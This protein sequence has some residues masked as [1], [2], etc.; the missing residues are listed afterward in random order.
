[1]ENFWKI[2][3][4][5]SVFAFKSPWV[6]VILGVAIIGVVIWD[7]IRRG[8]FHKPVSFIKTLRREPSRAFWI[9]RLNAKGASNY[10]LIGVGTLFSMAVAVP[11]NFLLIKRGANY[12]AYFSD[13]FISLASLVATS[14]VLTISLSILVIQRSSE[15]FSS[16][17]TRIYIQ[18][19]KNLITVLSLSSISIVAYALSLP[20]PKEFLNPIGNYV[21]V[22]L[23]LMVVGVTLD[24]IRLHYVH[25]SRL[26]D[27]NIATNLF[28]DAAITRIRKISEDIIRLRKFHSAKINLRAEEINND[29]F[30]A[31]LYK[32]HHH[33]RNELSSWIE[34]LIATSR[35][36]QKEMSNNRLRISLAGVVKILSAYL[37]IRKNKILFEYSEHGTLE[38]DVNVIL[39]SLCD[40]L[41]LLG[42]RAIQ[43]DDEL[44]AVEIARTFCALATISLKIV[45]GADVPLFHR[46]ILYLT[47]YLKA[48]KARK[49]PE[50]GWN[51]SGMLQKFP[52]A[53]PGGISKV[54]ALIAIIDCWQEAIESY[55]GKPDSQVLVGK[56]YVAFWML[57]LEFI[58]D[59]YNFSVL[60][61]RYKKT[62]TLYIGRYVIT[63]SLRNMSDWGIRWPYQPGNEG[64]IVGPLETLSKRIST[65]EDDH[66]RY[67]G[68]TSY[69]EKVYEIFS[70]PIRGM[71]IGDTPLAESFIDST[72]FASS[73]FLDLALE[74]ERKK[75]YVREIESQVIRW[76]YLPQFMFKD[77]TDPNLALIKR[78]CDNAVVVRATVA[79]TFLVEISKCAD[80]IILESVR[81]A[82]SK[83][84][85][86]AWDFA[87]I[88]VLVR[89]LEIILILK[90]FQ[91]VALKMGREISEMME[92]LVESNLQLA[93]DCI[94]NR[95][96]HFE[97]EFEESLRSTYRSHAYRSHQVVIFELV[98]AAKEN[99]VDPEVLL[100]AI[101][102]S[103]E[104]NVANP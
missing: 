97:T 53:L 5:S 1:M 25:T 57:P 63:P 14:L 15:S 31:L 85:T 28:V 77:A 79:G 26:L 69:S 50:L 92:I 55:L 8:S 36:A 68:I 52:S 91:A 74:E 49:I 73:I 34:D 54:P 66:H 89:S 18:D 102:Q 58:G 103:L 65:N 41:R 75:T 67:S 30:E 32:N 51:T 78:I 38:S 81:K 94:L 82:I 2:Y 4:G 104:L 33:H 44:A 6:E 16:S 29:Q 60:I 17:I 27:F 98:K 99:D 48:D 80:K 35:T 7:S 64:S 86:K 39:D 61:S 9:M 21:L 95:L 93:K 13:L 62:S 42:G 87:D 59:P 22:T 101:T 76:L 3:L 43:D 10:F 71:P 100:R 23:A 12:Q 88:Y 40:H 24:I 84:E 37:D 11:V 90:G 20:F 96:G 56:M 83:V 19:V 70:D 45:A 72:I 47:S 46:P